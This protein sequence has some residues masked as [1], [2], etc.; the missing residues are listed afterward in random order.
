MHLLLYFFLQKTYE[1][2]NIILSQKNDLLFI[3]MI[4]HYYLKACKGNVMKTF[5]TYD[6]GNSD[7][8]FPNPID[9]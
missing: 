1:T 3:I 5:I 6:F 4:A 9:K 8:S 7:F 2:F